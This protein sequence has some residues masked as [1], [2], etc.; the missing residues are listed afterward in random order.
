MKSLQGCLGCWVTRD[1]VTADLRLDSFLKRKY[2]KGSD[3]LVTF[4]LRGWKPGLWLA[5]N[6]LCTLSFLYF[7]LPADQTIY[8]LVTHG[9]DCES[10]AQMPVA[11]TRWLLGGGSR[12]LSA[13]MCWYR[14]SSVGRCRVAGNSQHGCFSDTMTVVST[15]G[16]V[17]L[18]FCP[19]EGPVTPAFLVTINFNGLTEIC[20]SGWSKSVQMFCVGLNLEIWIWPTA[21]CLH[22]VTKEGRLWDS[23]Q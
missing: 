8:A 16:L 6:S 13:G 1:T 14:E 21:S 12:V 10:V 18:R 5:H 23:S 11:H 22:T 3:F 2:T 7:C 4:D 9:A 19:S 20:S 15:L 17:I